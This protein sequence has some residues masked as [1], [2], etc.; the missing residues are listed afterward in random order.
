MSEK[1]AAA[2]LVEF[3][4]ACPS[5]FHTAAEICRRLDAAGAGGI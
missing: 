2:G 1:N 5:M 3:V 4:R